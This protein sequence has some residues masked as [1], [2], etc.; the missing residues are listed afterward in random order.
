MEVLSWSAFLIGDPAGSSGILCSAGIHP[1]LAIYLF[2]CMDKRPPKF[3]IFVA[4]GVA[5]CCISIWHFLAEEY[6]TLLVGHYLWIAGIALILS[7]P[8]ANWIQ[9]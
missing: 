1:L 4:G 8:L 9:G 3:L 5:G 7:A 2:F 6:A